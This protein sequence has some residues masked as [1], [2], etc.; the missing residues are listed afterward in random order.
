MNLKE[1]TI[2]TL[3]TQTTQNKDQKKNEYRDFKENYAWKE[4]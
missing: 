2:K 4:G 3:H 1:I